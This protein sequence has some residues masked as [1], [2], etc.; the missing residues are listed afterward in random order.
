[1]DHSAGSRA[2]LFKL[3]EVESKILES[4]R[5]NRGSRRAQLLPVCLLGYKLSALG[6]DH[7]DRMRH[8]LA[9]LWVAQ[10]R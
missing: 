3:F 4:M 1:M 10:N 8:I 2:A 5:A 7:V 9:Q 6:L